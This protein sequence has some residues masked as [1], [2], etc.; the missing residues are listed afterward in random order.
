LSL[1]DCCSDVSFNNLVG[2]IPT[3]IK[4]ERLKFL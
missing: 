4:L 3:N 1:C 2:E